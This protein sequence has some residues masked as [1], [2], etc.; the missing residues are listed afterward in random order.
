MDERKY[1]YDEENAGIEMV[2]LML[3]QATDLAKEAKTIAIS[4]KTH[5]CNKESELEYM[6]QSI[7]ESKEAMG[8]ISDTNIQVVEEL[9]KWTWFRV[10]ITPLAVLIITTAAGAFA[11]FTYMKN[12]IKET[13]QRQDSAIK[14]IK[15]VRDTQRSLMDVVD[16]NDADAKRYEENMKSIND[17][18]ETISAYAK[19]NQSIKRKR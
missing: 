9:S 7:I 6:K 4:A 13:K 2:K 12:D 16:E 10:L 15:L 3:K 19:G 11:S 18:L 14:E 17:K 8:K 5:Q 1:R